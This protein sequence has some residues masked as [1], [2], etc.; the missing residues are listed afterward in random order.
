MTDNILGTAVIG[1]W[2]YSVESYEVTR[3]SIATT[4]SWISLL[5]EFHGDTTL[6]YYTEVSRISVYEASYPYWLGNLGMYKGSMI[7]AQ[8]YHNALSVRSNNKWI[9]IHSFW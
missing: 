1:I 7:H 6:L 4:G 3:L 9:V 2:L 5:I 8:I